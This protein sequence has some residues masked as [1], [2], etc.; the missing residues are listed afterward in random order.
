MTNVR[1]ANEPIAL[2]YGGVSV[3]HRE[4]KRVLGVKYIIGFQSW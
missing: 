1:A 4:N 3:M 2:G